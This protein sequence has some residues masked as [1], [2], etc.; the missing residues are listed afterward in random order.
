[1]KNVYFSDLNVILR[2]L[3]ASHDGDF[4]PYEVTHAIS[5]IWTWSSR[6]AALSHY[7]RPWKD[8]DFIVWRSERESPSQS[9]DYN[10]IPF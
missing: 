6:N 7:H 10:D 8:A 3:I 2:G 4:L 5:C 1:M 9:V